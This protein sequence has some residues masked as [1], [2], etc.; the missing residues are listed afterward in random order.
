[1]SQVPAASIIPFFLWHSST[2]VMSYW[3]FF[4]V[5]NPNWLILGVLMQK[6]PYLTYH[7]LRIDELLKCN[8]FITTLNFSCLLFSYATINQPAIFVYKIE[9]RRLKMI[10]PGL[11][12]L[13][14]RE[15]CKLLFGTKNYSH[16]DSVL[17]IHF[18]SI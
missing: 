14:L 12:S 1:M 5:G 13:Q 3:I 16:Q 7:G 8:S 17:C 15:V 11:D 6:F 10:G 9:P 18:T 2:I 4:S